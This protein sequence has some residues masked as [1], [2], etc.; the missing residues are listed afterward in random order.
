[1]SLVVALYAIR[2]RFLYSE[3]RHFINRFYGS[4]ISQV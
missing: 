4:V 3:P 1:M 2:V